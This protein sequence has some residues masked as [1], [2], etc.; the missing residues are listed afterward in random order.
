M[1]KETIFFFTL[2]V[3][4]IFCACDS[5]FRILIRHLCKFIRKG[6][7]IKIER[8]AWDEVSSDLS[9][10]CDSFFVNSLIDTT[11]EIDFLCQYQMEFYCNFNKKN[12]DAQ[13]CCYKRT[14]YQSVWTKSSLNL[15][16]FAKCSRKTIVTVFSS[17]CI[18]YW[19][20]I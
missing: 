18:V 3:G 10:W 9:Q 1:T 7:S 8:A 5:P 11:F 14:N 2:F 16:L 6:H 4:L 20:Q 19:I 12:S 13:S 15:L 17:S